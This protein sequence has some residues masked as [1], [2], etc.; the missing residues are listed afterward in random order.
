MQQFSL[1]CG[2]N[3]YSHIHQLN[4]LNVATYSFSWPQY[5]VFLMFEAAFKI[6]II[7]TL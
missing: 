3:I 4:K 6:K 7:K 2:Q 5:L 1:N